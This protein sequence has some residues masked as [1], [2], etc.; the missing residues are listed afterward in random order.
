MAATLSLL[1]VLCTLLPTLAAAQSP[2]AD[3]PQISG[4][5]SLSQAVMT[6]VRENRMLQVA[7][8][9][10]RAAAA[11]TRSARSQ[12]RPQA[13]LNTYLTHGDSANIVSTSSGIMPLNTLAIPPLPFADQN[14][15]L[16]LPLYTGGRLEGQVRAASEQEHAVVSDVAAAQAE[17][18]LLIREAYYRALLAAEMVKAAQARI[19]SDTAML[20][21]TRAQV[22]AGKGI[23]ASVNR[24]EAE[25]ADAQRMLTSARSDQTK[26]LLDL[27]VAMGV[28]LE[29]EIT[30]SDPLTFLTPERNLAASLSQATRSRPELLAMRRRIGAAKAQTGVAKSAF[31]PQI[32]GLVMADAFASREKSSG[33]YSIGI[34]VSL[35]LL[36]GGQRR[37]EVDRARAMQ[38]RAEA[39]A[40]DLE[41]RV[42]NEVRQGWLDVE[43]AAQNYQTA[44]AALKAA[45]S[46]YDVTA[47]RVQNQKSILVEQL[48][49][50]AALTQARANL[51]RA[52]YEQATA[53]A[54]LRRAVGDP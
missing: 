35:P 51:A 4:S 28:K 43:T 46:A 38:D 36:D 52:L 16:M 33:G 37:A 3:R 34:T 13:S 39:E 23:E 40:Q 8:A 2:R 49:A 50:L 32:Y 10:L 14:L 18:A 11:G 48:D 26:A 19:D 25:L 44:I 22:E 53:I 9:D 31:Q 24:I 12:T 15:T 30:L 5:L 21:V 17:V 41:L 47:L 1:S 27:K 6:G 42:A 45:Q 7:Q 54:R 20:Q 29:S